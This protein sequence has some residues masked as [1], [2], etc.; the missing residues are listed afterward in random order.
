VRANSGKAF[1]PDFAGSN[2]EFDETWCGQAD[3][4]AQMHAIT[5]NWTACVVC[6]NMVAIDLTKQV[7]P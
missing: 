3:G 5:K 2:S 7:L 4:W 1:V 6:T